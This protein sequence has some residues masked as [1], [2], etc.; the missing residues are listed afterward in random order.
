MINRTLMNL[1]ILGLLAVCSAEVVAQSPKRFSASV[2]TDNKQPVVVNDLQLEFRRSGP[3]SYNPSEYGKQQTV[4]LGTG[5][6][7][8]FDRIA[9]VRFICRVDSSK[10]RAIVQ[11]LIKTASGQAV[12][13]TLE[14]PEAAAAYLIGTTDLGGFEL[15]LNPYESREVV[16]TFS[17]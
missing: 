2:V 4:P 3:G 12:E 14:G 13:S 5:V 10:A 6:K 9:D 15:R 8:G 11:V 1:A 17:R 16:V 7:V